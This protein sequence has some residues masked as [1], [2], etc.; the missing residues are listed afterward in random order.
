MISIQVCQFRGQ[1]GDALWMRSSKTMV[2]LK[3]KY[4]YKNDIILN[5]RLTCWIEPPRVASLFSVKTRKIKL[6]PVLN[7]FCKVDKALLANMLVNLSPSIWISTTVSLTFLQKITTIHLRPWI[8]ERIS[9]MKVLTFE[10]GRLA[11]VFIVLAPFSGPDWSSM[12]AI[13]QVSLSCGH[14]CLND[15]PCR[16]LWIQ[17]SK[18][19]I[20][21]FLPAKTGSVQLRVGALPP[22]VKMRCFS[23]TKYLEFKHPNLISISSLWRVIVHNKKFPLSHRYWDRTV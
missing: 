22:S 12:G 2:D 11:K 19:S 5:S 17:A 21:L 1:T 3:A 13:S 4:Q 15:I 14:L 7:T 6:P 20:F 10:S 18:L 8:F 23:C 9:I 16:P